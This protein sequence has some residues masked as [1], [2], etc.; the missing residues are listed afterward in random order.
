VNKIPLRGRNLKCILNKDKTSAKI[1][2]V[3]PVSW[4]LT[5]L[6]RYTIEEMNKGKKMS[7]IIWDGNNTIILAENYNNSK[8]LKKKNRN[9]NK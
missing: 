2:S 5:F 8:D 4:I 6:K 7:K 9:P 1:F 3:K